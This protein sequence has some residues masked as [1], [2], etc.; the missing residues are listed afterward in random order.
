MVFPL[1]KFRS[2]LIGSKVI[3]YTNH[4]AVKHLMSKKDAKPRLICW[5]LL[6]QEFN[7]EIRDK[8]G[9]ENVVANH[10]SRI[11][12]G[13]VN[14]Q[15]SL[16]ESFPDKHLFSISQLPW[17]VD[18]VNYLAT[19]AIPK[20]WNK[21]DRSKFLSEVKH[22]FWDDPYLFKYCSDQVIRRCI[23]DHEVQ[24]ILSFCHSHACGGHFGAKR[25]QQKFFNRVSIGL[26]FFVIL[27]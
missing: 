11:I 13:N 22:F 7:I 15:V 23:P 25:Q 3:I 20:K 9:F 8:K 10:L 12:T 27:M 19:S 6:V 17:Y 24:S 16:N 2:Y 18:I 21:Q 5:V 1:D 14:D 26:L 4:S